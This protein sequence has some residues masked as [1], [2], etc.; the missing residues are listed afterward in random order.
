MVDCD[1]FDVIVRIA[2]L[3]V[4]LP[5]A[6][7]L[8]RAVGD[9]LVGVHVRRGAGAALEHVEPE[10]IVKLAVDDFLAGAFDPR[11]DRLVERPHSA[12]ARAAASFTIA[13]ALIRSG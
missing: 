9:H 5:V 1:A 13:S 3:I 2:V 7:Q 11:E 12:L 8:E 4:A 6:H 10:L